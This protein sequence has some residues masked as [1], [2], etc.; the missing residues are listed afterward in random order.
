[1]NKF[2]EIAVLIVLVLGIGFAMLQ[3]S[4]AHCHF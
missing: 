2:Y 3:Q 4:G 1:M